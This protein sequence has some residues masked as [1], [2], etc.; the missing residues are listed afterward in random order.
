MYIKQFK[1]GFERVPHPMHPDRTV[2]KPQ[3]VPFPGVG[4]LSHGGVKYE[5]DENGW[6]DVPHE[7]GVAL[8]GDGFQLAK[9]T[10]AD[11]VAFYTEAEVGEEFRLGFAE[12][13]AA[14]T[15]A[16]KAEAPRTFAPPPPP[17]DD[18]DDEV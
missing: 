18:D 3:L 10:S 1:R 12:Q 15:R 2:K 4:S 5:P 16:A 11:G 6:F 9:R 13:V 8:A 17:A 7:V 14:P